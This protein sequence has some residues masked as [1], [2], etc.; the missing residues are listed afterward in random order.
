MEEATG[1]CGNLE[2]ENHMSTKGMISAVHDDDLVRFLDGIGALAEVESGR[3]KCKFC[4]QSVDLENLAAVFPESGDI[5]FV[6][7]RRG[8]LADLAEHRSEV[9]GKERPADQQCGTS[10]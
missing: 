2:S 7:D 10:L 4:R 5:K 6:C 9:R 3:A 8:C 1:E